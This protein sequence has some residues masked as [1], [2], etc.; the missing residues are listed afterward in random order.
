MEKIDKLLEFLLEN[1]EDERINVYKKYKY[2]FKNY[3][4]N[5]YIDEDPNSK[6][7]VSS[8]HLFQYR[9]SLEVVFDNRNKCI[10]IFGGDEQHP[11]VIENEE[12]LLKWSNILE[13]IVSNN[14]ENR[15]VDVFEKTLNDCFNKNLYRELQMKKLFK[16]DESL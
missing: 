2:G 7:H 3:Y 9:D 15:A 12:L 16:S 8:H 14:L 6:N 10:E 13:D 4:L 11:L 5:F 1:I